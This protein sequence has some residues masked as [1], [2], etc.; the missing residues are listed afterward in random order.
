MNMDMKKIENNKLDDREL[1]EVTGGSFIDTIINF[2][3]GKKYKS[4]TTEKK[5]I[6]PH[7]KST[8]N[9]SVM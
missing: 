6:S 3:S 2:F 4:D 5:A 8:G 9:G 7:V 1:K